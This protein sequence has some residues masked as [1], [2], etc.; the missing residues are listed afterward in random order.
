MTR[1]ME[2][3]EVSAHALVLFCV[4]QIPWTSPDML[5][6]CIPTVYIKIWYCTCTLLFYELPF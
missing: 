6:Q 5:L 4:F 2:Q 3:P 1:A